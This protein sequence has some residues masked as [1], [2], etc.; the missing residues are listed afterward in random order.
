MAEIPK[1]E[2]KPIL[3]KPDEKLLKKVLSDNK[4][5]KK[6]SRYREEAP[7]FKDHKAKSSDKAVKKL[8]KG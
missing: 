7:S 2:Q 5:L 8:N 3:M 6:A 1:I 4:A